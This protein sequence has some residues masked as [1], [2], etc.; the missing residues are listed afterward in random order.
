M[1]VP[2]L[3]V[4]DV[5]SILEREHEHDPNTNRA[6]GLA[7]RWVRPRDNWRGARFDPRFAPFRDDPQTAGVASRFVA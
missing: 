6:G 1:N 7:G 5:A 4:N 2:A 3:V